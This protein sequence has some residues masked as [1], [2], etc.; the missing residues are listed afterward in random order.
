VDDLYVLDRYLRDAKSPDPAKR[1][2]AA[3]FYCK[4]CGQKYPHAEGVEQMLRH[5]ETVHADRLRLVA[6]VEVS[7]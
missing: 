6:D 3:F 4:T 5:I 7:K 2:G 1:N